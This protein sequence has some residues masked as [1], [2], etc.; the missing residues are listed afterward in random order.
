[1]TTQ[2]A[3]ILAAGRGSR[4]GMHETLPKPL[5][6]VGGLPLIVRILRKLEL[7]GVMEVGVVVGY[8][9]QAIRHA[10][11]NHHFDMR[12]HTITNAAWEK[13]NGTSLLSAR[14]FIDRPTLVLM[15]D[16]LFALPL[17][18]RVQRHFVGVD[19]VAL[20]VD[21]RPGRCF[22]IE[23]AT[24]VQMDGS[25]ITGIGKELADY[26]ALDTGVFKVTP[27]LIRALDAVNGPDGC[28]LSQ[29]IAILA[30][31][32]KM[33]GVDIGDAAWI[34][35]DTPKAKRYAETYLTRYDELPLV[36]P[37][38]PAMALSA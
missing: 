3:V 11:A 37:M 2:R 29:G 20:G 26:D 21:Y 10:L 14:D 34:D 25:R 24:K 23:D 13:P 30:R 33:H 17:L 1:M 12:V 27:A 19:E 8:L 32:G 28:S 22:D 15:S 6:P 16:H 35:V 4:L 9:G 31:Q 5:Q 36:Q 38:A 18:E 7:S